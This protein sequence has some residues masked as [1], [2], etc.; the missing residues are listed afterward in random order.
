M[1]DNSQSQN[2]S[3]RKIVSLA[4]AR[5]K[6][7]ERFFTGVPCKRGHVSERST[8]W[9]ACLECQSAKHSEWLKSH[10]E[11]VR[12]QRIKDYH[13]DVEVS[14]AKAKKRREDDTK[15]FRKYKK[16]DYIKHKDRI[17]A[18]SSARYYQDPKRANAG[19]A[20]WSKRNPEKR[21]AIARKWASLNKETGR[22][23]REA[24]TDKIRVYVAVSK[25]R[26]RSRIEDAGGKFTKS[27][28]DRIYKAQKGKCAYCRT[29]L[30]NGYHIDHIQP[31][32]RLGSNYPR[33]LQLCCD[34][35]NHSKNARDPI[36]YA[37]S[38]GRLL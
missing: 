6:G 17:K 15:T 37:Q 12:A 31:L 26:R 33:N 1:A 10:P 22:E 2:D 19:S 25:S 16:A 35:C 28:I 29:S 5:E 21:R 8:K 36:E 27:D 18:A 32:A 3:E 7:L 24:N 11:R 23:W 34:D 38:T 13:K 20:A 9:R 30:K 14:R 4:E